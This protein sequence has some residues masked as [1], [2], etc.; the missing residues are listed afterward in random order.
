MTLS[1]TPDFTANRRLIAVALVITLGAWAV[2]AISD[3]DIAKSLG[4]TDDAMRLVIVR[5]LLHGQGWYD[6]LVTRLQPPEG[7]YMH[8]SRLLDG[9][10]ASLLWLVGRVTTPAWA[11]LIV[12]FTWPLLWIAP[13]VV[14]ALSIARSLGGRLAVFCCAILMLTNTQLYV[15][16]VPGRID[17]HN[18]Q[19]TMAVTAVACAM[20]RVQRT[21]FAILAGVASGLGL[22]VGIEALAF[23]ALAGASY[24]ISAALDPE[25][26]KPARAYGLSLAGATTA[27]FCLQTPPDRWSLSFCEGIGMNLVA[28]ILVAGLGV[29]AF[30]TWGARAKVELRF[31]QIGLLGASAAAV[32]LAVD[33]ACIRGPF[34]AVD[35]RLGPIWFNNISELL[36]WERLWVLHRDSA[37]ITIFMSCLGAAAALM[38]LAIRWRRWDRATLLAAALVLIAAVSASRAWRMED[39]AFWYGVPTLAAA[40]GWLAE[41]FFRGTMVATALLSL[42]L[43][44]VPLAVGVDAAL[45]A[46]A[47]AAPAQS[48]AAPAAAKP[49]G[50]QICSDVALYRPLAALP[51]GVVLGEIDLG[52]H[53]LANTSDSVLA[54]PYPRMSRGILG[55]YEALGGPTA[56]AQARLKALNVTYVLDCRLNELRFNPAGFEGDLRRGRIP[57]W[58]QP[59]SGPGDPMQIYRVRP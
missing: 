7:I 43:S 13:A 4:D 3:G 38:L 37:L 6:Q 11:E 19:I 34:A 54:A 56:L 44:P 32:Y 28:A 29:A 50:D 33:P 57:P 2:L 55:G 17:H 25:E 40:L 1:D 51:P 22:A 59:L 46:I 53:V 30:A 52:P 21:R 35:P 26:A 36:P 23:H 48:H 5:S 18:V 20:A 9:A 58:V 15:Q 47:K 8:W 10:L 16:F 24:A 39:Y 27:F 14:A 49:A 31:A 12:R 45:T 41:R 42:A